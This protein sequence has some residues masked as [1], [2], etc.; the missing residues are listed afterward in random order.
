LVSK[1]G[2]KLKHGGPHR[3][4][5]NVGISKTQKAEPSKRTEPA[6]KKLPKLPLPR[7]E[8]TLNAYL[9]SIEAIA[10][11][12]ELA[13]TEKIVA[14]F[15]KPDSVGPKLH[16]RLQARV[17]DPE[18]D[19]WL[20]DLYNESN[21]LDRNTALAPFGS[22][23]STHN[24]SKTPHRQAE[25]ATVIT[26]AARKYRELYKKG[27]VKPEQLN[28]QDT[29]MYSMQWLFGTHRMPCMGR[30][31]MQRFEDEEEEY[32]VVLRFGRVFMVV[33]RE[34]EE[35]VPYE[36]LEATF[37]TILEK[38]QENDALWVS[39]LTA[40]TRNSWAKVNFLNLEMGFANTA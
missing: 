34:G 15:L 12:S 13:N 10:T 9:S 36:T 32:I 18:I 33:I 19:C 26:V 30:D 6:F 1:K 11:P 25:R 14:N 8:N 37:E 2:S 20:I 35:D 39:V 4:Q 28:G 22:F 23:F 27:K 5:E 17:E 7:L 16:A 24:L 3:P 21:F 40:D 31:R 29:C 38:T